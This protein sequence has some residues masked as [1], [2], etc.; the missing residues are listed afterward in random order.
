MT[1]T[2]KQQ[3]EWGDKG[4]NDYL[5]SISVFRHTKSDHSLLEETNLSVTSIL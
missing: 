1:E 4:A 2:K 3:W 5:A